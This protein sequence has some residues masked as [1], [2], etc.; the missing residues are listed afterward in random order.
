MIDL[1]D[2]TRAKIKI[3]RHHM[4]KKQTRGLAYLRKENSTKYLAY[5]LE[6]VTLE[7]PWKENKRN[8]SCIPTGLY[9]AKKY[10]SYQHNRTV[11]L[12][13]DVPG[14]SWIEMHPGN[15][16]NDTRGCILPGESFID[17]TDDV[18]FVVTHSRKTMDK[19]LSMLPDEF[20]VEITELKR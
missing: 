3:V 8:I 20:V 1:N 11:I 13:L 9:R 16:T 6:F 7:L 14:R 2:R 17:A 4:T 12:L 15:F 5:D 18:G 19:I 10:Y